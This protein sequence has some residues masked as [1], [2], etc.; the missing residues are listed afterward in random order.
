MLSFCI[1]VLK[2]ARPPQ[3]ERIFRFAAAPQSNFNIQ[4]GGNSGGSP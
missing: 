3:I 1:F 4:T 2:K